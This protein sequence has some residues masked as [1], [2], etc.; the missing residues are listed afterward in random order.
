VPRYYFHLRFDHES[1]DRDGVE[2]P[3]F[4]AA[5]AE[6]IRSFGEML[7]IRDGSLSPDTPFEMVIADENGTQLCRL[8]FATEMLSPPV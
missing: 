7:R 2:L 6:A 1:I 5:W 8:R 3:D 4:Q